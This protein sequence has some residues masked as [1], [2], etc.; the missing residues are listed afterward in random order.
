MTAIVK[1]R[2]EMPEYMVFSYYG[3]DNRGSYGFSISMQRK[4]GQSIFVM[5]T[6]AKLKPLYDYID[7]EGY[8]YREEWLREI[9]K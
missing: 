3:K 1:K 5:P 7:D 6:G 9:K 2:K 4:M 8:C